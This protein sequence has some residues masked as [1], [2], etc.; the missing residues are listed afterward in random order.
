MIVRCTMNVCDWRIPR[1]SQR[2][3]D[4]D[5]PGLGSFGV[6][7]KLVECFTLFI[8]VFYRTLGRFIIVNENI[9][10]TCQQETT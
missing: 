6:S 4:K 7:A 3:S 5:P 10:C 8:K 9:L 2:G 1:S